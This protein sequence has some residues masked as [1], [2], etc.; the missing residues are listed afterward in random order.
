MLKHLQN[1]SRLPE[2]ADGFTT[3]EK[4]AL[5]AGIADAIAAFFETKE[6]AGSGS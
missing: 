5:A 6:G 3:G 4:L 1:L 2:K